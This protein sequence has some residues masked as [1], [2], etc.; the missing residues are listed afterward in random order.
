MEKR[1]N[2]TSTQREEAGR[3]GEEAFKSGVTR[4]EEGKGSADLDYFR[5]ARL[6]LSESRATLTFYSNLEV[7]SIHYD[8]ERDEVFYKGH[9]VKNMTL[10]ESQIEALQKFSDY[11]SQAPQAKKMRQAYRD[12]L[13]RLFPKRSK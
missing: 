10:S 2:G 6:F 4:G 5:E 12:C 9:N 8:M 13:N 1:S 7:A 11:L 3:I